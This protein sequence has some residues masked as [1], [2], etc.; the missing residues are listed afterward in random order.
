[1]GGVDP[2]VGSP[3]HNMIAGDLELVDR[4]LCG[5]GQKLGISRLKASHVAIR[6]RIDVASVCH[7][8]SLGACFETICRC[9]QKR[10]EEGLG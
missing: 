6:R 9:S 5:C 1:M 8:G 4:D 10:S 7:C 3:A 2:V